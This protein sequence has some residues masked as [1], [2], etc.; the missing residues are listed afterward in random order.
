MKK[1]LVPTLVLA[2]LALGIAGIAWAGQAAVQVP[3][4]PA[5]EA[6][7]P[8]EER[9]LDEITLEG[10]FQEPVEV[11]AC[12]RGNC[13]GWYGDCMYACNADPICEQ[14]CGDEKQAC[15]AGC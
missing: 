5:A 6:G 14:E 7:L 12:C 1:T 4:E 15:L 13:L 3:E 11:D 10:L 9:E 2:L 8:A